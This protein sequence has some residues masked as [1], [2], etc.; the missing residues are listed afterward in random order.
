VLVRRVPLDLLRAVAMCLLL[1][2]E[3]RWQQLPAEV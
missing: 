2:G 3:I 1:L